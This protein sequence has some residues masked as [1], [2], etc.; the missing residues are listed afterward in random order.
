MKNNIPLI[1]KELKKNKITALIAPSFVAEFSYPDI[2][3][4]LKELGFDKIVELTFG[5][6]MINR[7]YHKI[8][9]K[10]D[11]FRI[12]SVCPGIVEIIKSRYPKF[13]ENLMTVDSPMTA[14]AKICRKFYPKYK[15]NSE[16]L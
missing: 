16:A 12:S 15:G 9:E 3:V 13:K 11:K 2:L 6:K 4:K 7:E 10:T 1:E 14:T 5:A 8:S